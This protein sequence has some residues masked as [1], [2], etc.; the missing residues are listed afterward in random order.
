MEACLADSERMEAD[1]MLTRDQLE[2]EDAFVTPREHFSSSGRKAIGPGGR[3]S[4]T[5]PGEWKSNRW[6]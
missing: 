5:R 4:A 2:E 1:R 6:P 3:K